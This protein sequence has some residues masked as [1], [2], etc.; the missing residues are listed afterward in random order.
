MSF[1][2]IA[3][4]VVKS[5]KDGKPRRGRGFTRKELENAGLTVEDARNMGLIVDLRRRTT[6]EQNVEILKEY[7]QDMED[8]VSA[9]AAEET[10]TVDVS[11]AID[12]LSSLKAV[13]VENAKLLVEAGILSV[14][15]LA[16]CEIDKVANKTGIDEEKL[17]KMVKAALNKV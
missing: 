17:T 10:S 6:Y 4:P 2:I 13:S 12:E 16:Y 1:D 8:I 14:S 5:P 15:D 7:I 9:L 3:E 11:L